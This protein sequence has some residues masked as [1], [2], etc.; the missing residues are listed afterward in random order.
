MKY[1]EACA[2]LK[3]KQNLIGTKTEKGVTID[4]LIIVPSDKEQREQFFDMSLWNKN[5]A[6]AILRFK[7]CDVEVWG[8]DLSYL[9]EKRVLF[10]KNIES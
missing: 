4:Q 5:F 7:D 8:I 9:V 10:Y 2:L 6:G 1:E 3:N